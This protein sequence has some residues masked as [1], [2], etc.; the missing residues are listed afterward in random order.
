MSENK[1]IVKNSIILYAR[2]LITIIIGLYSSRIILLE[3]G[4]ED[5]G[6]YAVVGGI[7][8]LMNLLSTTMVTTSIRFIAV[9]IGKKE[10]K[11]PNKIF[12]SLLLLHITLSLVLLL[13]AETLGV[14]YVKNYLNA[15]IEKIPDALFVLRL[16]TFAAVIDS[17]IM[18]FQG[19]I[20]VHEK[21][22][23]KA[24]IENTHSLL[25]LGVVFL[26]IFHTGNKLRAYAMYV[27]VVHLFVALAYFLY[28]RLKYAEIVKWKVN[29]N[30][31]DY[32][33][34][35]KFFGWQMVYVVGAVGSRQGGAIILN[36]FFGTALNAAFGI[37]NRV[38]EFILSFG[39]NLNQAAVPQIMKSYSGDNQ[40]RSLMLIYKLSKFTFFIML[41]PGVPILLSIDSILVLWLKEVPKYTAS[42]VVLMMFSGLLISLVNPLDVTIDAS[43]EIGKTKTIYTLLSLS[44]LPAAYFLFKLKFPPFSITLLVIFA[45]IIFIAVQARILTTLTN[46]KIS[47]YFSKTLLPVG[48]VTLLVLPQFFLRFVF[49]EGIVNLFLISLISL[50]LTIITIYLAGLNKEEKMIIYSII[51]NNRFIGRFLKKTKAW[52]L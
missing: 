47:D 52:Y 45:Q 40:E 14:W 44:S 24:L 8:S 25:H 16:S 41:I 12:N 50:F 23:F 36:L 10:N 3:L 43:G 39:R 18:P 20:T 11:N 1:R 21:F 28:S 6:L 46:F 30:W 22:S 7:V 31:N 17:I 38:N 48:I 32:K 29:R 26:L 42:F 15:A 27:L 19:L 2:L 37:A 51:V 34:V 4:V 5:F 13:V 35:S 33:S 9:E 49:S